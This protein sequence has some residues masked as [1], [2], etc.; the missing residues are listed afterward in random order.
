MPFLDTSAP[1][2]PEVHFRA[3]SSQHIQ[4]MPRVYVYV[5]VPLHKTNALNSAQTLQR[6]VVHYIPSLD[7]LVGFLTSVHCGERPPCFVAIDSL[8]SYI[9]VC[10]ANF[11]RATALSQDPVI[12]I[13]IHLRIF[14]LFVMEILSNCHSHLALHHL[15]HRR[16]NSG[17]KKFVY[18]GYERDR[19]TFFLVCLFILF[20]ILR[21]ENFIRHF[22]FVFFS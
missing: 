17:H 19:E 5:C 4:D 12:A 8:E 7:E 13:F 9:A 22:V 10:N 14:R 16:S 6:V 11:V 18:S 15:L 1:L 3:A 2:A 21:R 20:F